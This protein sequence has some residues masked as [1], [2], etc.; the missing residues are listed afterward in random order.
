MAVWP[1]GAVGT[2]D[3]R[4]SNNSSIQWSDL[5]VNDSDLG[6]AAE[7][8]VVNWLNS[9]RAFS[10]LNVRHQP[11]GEYG[12]DLE[13]ITGGVS[14]GIGVEMIL[15]YSGDGLYPYESYNLNTYKRAKKMISG[16]ERVLF[17]VNR[18]CTHAHVLLPS[19]TTDATEFV[20]EY[21]PERRHR[22]H[23]TWA[24][25]NTFCPWSGK[26]CCVFRP[27][28]GCMHCV[29]L[30]CSIRA[31]AF[32]DAVRENKLGILDWNGPEPSK[33]N[34]FTPMIK[35]QGQPNGEIK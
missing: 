23:G 30:S 10:D 33:C 28:R 15:A 6:I 3:G 5:M 12:R 29:D 8:S 20:E 24:G 26:S 4:I 2:P 11:D 7:K 22:S 1:S 13:L 31:N 16:D 25:R 17:I 34:G 18:E 21:G 9:A 14:V 32:I 19:A 27:R 35:F